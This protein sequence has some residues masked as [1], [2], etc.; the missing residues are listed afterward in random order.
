MAL[1]AVL[2]LVQKGEPAFLAERTLRCLP[3]ASAAL[4]VEWS[5]LG[6]ALRAARSAFVLRSGAFGF[7]L[8]APPPSATGRPLLGLG[9]DPS[10]EAWSAL[11]ERT[12]G[13]LD[14][15][16]ALPE[17]GA[18]YVEHAF[19]LAE[20]VERSAG[21][22][23]AAALLASSGTHRALRLHSLDAGFSERMRVLEVITSLHRGGAEQVA[24]SLARDLHPHEVEARLAVLDA[25][26]RA[27][28]QAPPEALLLYE[29]AD[30]REARLALAAQA[31]RSGGYD[32]VHAHLL[33]AGELR[34]LR[35]AGAP[36]VTTLHNALPGLPEGLSTLQRG[37]AALVLACSRGVADEQ[38]AL[39][40]PLRTAWNGIDAASSGPGVRVQVREALGVGPGTLALLVL[41]NPRQQKRLHLAVEALAALRARGRDAVLLLAGA[42]LVTS[43]DAQRAEAALQA[44]IEA[45][46]LAPWVRRLGSREDAADLLAACDVA[47]S[48]SAW[49]GLSLAHL[50]SVAAGAPLVTTQTH[51]TEELARRHPAVRLVPLDASAPLLADAVEAAAAAPR[52]GPGLAA[53]FTSAAMALRHARLYRRVLAP[54]PRADGP[55]LLVTNNLSEGGAQSSARRLLEGLRRR[56]VAAACLVVEEQPEHPTPGRRALE[57]TGVPVFA[58]RSLRMAQVERVAAQALEV[59]DRERPR[60]VLFWNLA[61][62]LRVLLADALLETPVFDV[63]P[64]EMSYAALERYFA[65]PRE[66]L[67]I[68]DERDYGRLLAGVVAKYQGEAARAT[69][70]GAPVHVIRNGVPVPA[71]PPPL[72]AR[73]ERVVVGTLARLSPQKKLEELIDAVALLAPAL[74]D[75]LDLRIAGASELGGGAYGASLAQR[76]AGLPITFVGSQESGPF[77][78]QVELFAM[79]SEP[80]GCPNASLEA[81]AA[82]RP[83]LATDCGG[84]R[85]Q[86]AHGETGLLAPRADPAA[87]AE[88]LARLLGD[89]AL[90]M[91]MG[92]AG[93]ARA[94]AQFSVERMVDDYARLCLGRSG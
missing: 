36:L 31:V 74:R 59:V 70:L 79:I 90:A 68:L 34:V 49:E 88:A 89:R 11:L 65:A 61:A 54:G 94:A 15:E 32:L 82:G 83:V 6:A 91:R 57:A 21:L 86:V 38:T 72:P 42:P 14:G 53:A 5:G 75:R 2:L 66:G 27:A 30:T 80:A 39:Q 46:A 47:L 60:C 16:E 22:A 93:H 41:A 7:T 52:P 35:S 12:G 44:A 18:L 73:G 76:A 25:P 29:Q 51:G 24:R 19:D 58:T 71:R 37:D 10:D 81:M 78:A 3:G 84:A 33:G 4:R 45:H 28:L 77:L 92:A 48:T 13:V 20:A 87:F 67:P 64:G 26:R 63:S 17:T 40:V 69:V 43:G 85:E 9:A 56:G 1:P 23:Q 55:L 62:P 50:E 8:A